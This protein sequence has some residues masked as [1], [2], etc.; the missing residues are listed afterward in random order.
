MSKKKKSHRHKRQFTLPVAVA[1]GFL[2]GVMRILTHF[3]NPGLHGQSNGFS[4]AGVEASRVYLGLDPRDGSW[5]PGLLT[6]GLLPILLGGIVHRFVG[7]R[8]G[9]NRMLAGAGIPFLRL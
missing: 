4:A 8:L 5:N 7:G 2:P 3:Q 6:L 1:A 9:V